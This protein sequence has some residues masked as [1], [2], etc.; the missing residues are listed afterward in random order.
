[1]KFASV[2]GVLFKWT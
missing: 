1:M 2:Q